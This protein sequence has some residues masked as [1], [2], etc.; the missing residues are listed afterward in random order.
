MPHVLRG[1]HF[2][3]CDLAD[4]F[5]MQD[6]ITEAVTIAIDPVIAKPSGV[7]RAGRSSG[8]IRKFA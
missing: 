1:D 6:E 2:R 4:I 5:A 7:R 8:A 3:H